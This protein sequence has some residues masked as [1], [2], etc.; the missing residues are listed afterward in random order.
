MRRG[1]TLIEVVVAL[2]I[3]AVAC[4]LLVSA[5]TQSIARLGASQDME[6]AGRVAQRKMA[7][8]IQ[9]GRP[10]AEEDGYWEPLEATT[11]VDLQGQSLWWKKR[12]AVVPVVPDPAQTPDAASSLRLL[13]VWVRLAE[14]PESP[15][16]K[17]ATL[18]PPPPPPSPGP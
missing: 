13:E 9:A 10:D 1:F 17:L 11:D 4:T 7:E 15:V 3:L 5:G 12:V 18:Y 14:D 8:L 6:A 16:Y 2:A